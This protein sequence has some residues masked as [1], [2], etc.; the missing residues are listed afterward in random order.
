MADQKNVEESSIWQYCTREGKKRIK[1]NICHHVLH[2]PVTAKV[3]LYQDHKILFDENIDRS[4]LVWRYFI[5]VER[6]TSKCKFCH[7]LFFSAYDQQNLEDHLI[8]KHPQVAEEIRTEV[9]RMSV[10]RHFIFS[11]SR[12]Y[13]IKCTICYKLFNIFRVESLESHL[14]EH[15]R[16]EQ[17]QT[18]TEGNDTNMTI[19]QSVSE[20]NNASTPSQQSDTHPSQTEENQEDAVVSL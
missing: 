6:Y 2:S 8:I 20:E 10:S 16:N 7:K 15:R 17:S 13:R 18:S 9:E 4:S 5:E 3:H 12:R 1:C 14:L 11:T 19:N